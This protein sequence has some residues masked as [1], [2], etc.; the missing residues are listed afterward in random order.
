MRTIDLISIS[1]ASA[2]ALYSCLV[3][4]AMDDPGPPIGDTSTS[5]HSI[6]DESAL[7]HV[8]RHLE[9]HVMLDVGLFAVDGAM[10][11]LLVDRPN[12]GFS[13]A[14]NVDVVEIDWR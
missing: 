10:V 7:V 1:I 8:S 11:Y 4:G 5:T 12:S 2:L 3:P 13:L 14:L 6:V 9:R